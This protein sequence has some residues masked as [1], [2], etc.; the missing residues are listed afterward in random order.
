VRFAE[1]KR[2][3]GRNFWCET[4]HYPIDDSG[5]VLRPTQKRPRSRTDG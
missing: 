1:I 5:K 4:T 2:F 3:K